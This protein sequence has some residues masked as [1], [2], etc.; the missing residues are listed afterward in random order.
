MCVCACVCL[1]SGLSSVSWRLADGAIQCRF[2]R[3]VKLSDQEAARFD[4]Y[5]DYFLFLADGHAQN[6]E[7]V[8]T[9]IDPVETEPVDLDNHPASSRSYQ[10]VFIVS[11][12][13]L[14]V[15]FICG[16]GCH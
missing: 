11:Q 13:S 1:Q 5:Q 14:L 3:P 7:K 2:R 4:L 9:H 12:Q 6:G 15:R 16:T 8:H 10:S